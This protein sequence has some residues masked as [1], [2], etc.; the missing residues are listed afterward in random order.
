[1]KLSLK[2]KNILIGIS[3]GIAAYKIC[4]LINHF[5]KEG[6]DVRV[7]MTDAAKKFVTPLTFQALTNHPVYS[8]L[9]EI[10]DQNAVEHIWLAKW[11]HVFVLAPATANTIGKIAQGFADNMLTTVIMALPKK[12]KVV[13]A[14]AM[15]TEMWNNEIVQKNV[16]ILKKMDKYIFVD[17]RPGI[18]ACRDEGIGKVADSKDIISSVQKILS[19]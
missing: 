1:M 2:N 12:T 17:P 14:P 13:I 4:S 16:D 9:F 11:P 7:I 18:L 19:K 6:A 10:Y 15:N 5:I 8:D 3:G